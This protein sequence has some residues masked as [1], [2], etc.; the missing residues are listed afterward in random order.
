MSKKKIEKTDKNNPQRY[1][2]GE[3]SNISFNS[4]ILFIFF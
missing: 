3:F 2:L 4:S 1:N